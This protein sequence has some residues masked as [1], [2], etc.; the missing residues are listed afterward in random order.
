MPDSC[1]AVGCVNRR[2]VNQR[3]EGGKRI[4]F[5]RIPSGRT[6]LKQEKRRLW[7]RAIRRENWPDHQINRARICSD[8]FITGSCKTYCETKWSPLNLRG[9]MLASVSAAPRGDSAH[10]ACTVS[11]YVS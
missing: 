4:Q 10:V 3:N 11:H 2:K 5:Y 6:P 7:L 1:C 9:L 8:H